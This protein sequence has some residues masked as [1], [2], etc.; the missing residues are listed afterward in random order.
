MIFFW[1]IFFFITIIFICLIK[2]LIKFNSIINYFILQEVLGLLFLFL[3]N[4]IIQFFI[5]I[6]KIG[7]SPF[8]FW[9][10]SILINLD[11]NLIF[12]FLTYQKIPYII[13][14][15]NLINFLNFFLFLGVFVCFFQILFLMDFLKILLVNLTERISWVLLFLK[16]I[17]FDSMFIVVYYLFIVIFLRFSILKNIYTNWLIYLFLINLP[18]SF[19]FF[20]KILILSSLRGSALILFIILIFIIMRFFGVFKVFLSSNLNLKFIY[21]NSRFLF[22]LFLQFLVLFYY[23]SKKIIL[24]W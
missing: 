15:L 17:Y 5:L 8:H 10:F 6:I 2:R 20:I 9:I 13:I 21:F 19:N 14:F 12:W 7:A 3:N 11:T 18:L 24:S 16:N 1:I 4:N 22:Y 23:F